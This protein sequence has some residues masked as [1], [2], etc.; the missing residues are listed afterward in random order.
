MTAP[1]LMSDTRDCASEAAAYVLGAL[2]PEEAQAFR[3]HME[4]CV[5]CRDEV[6]A[7]QQ[8]A[9][10]LPMSAPQYQVPKGLRRR[11]LG[12]VRAEPRKPPE[13]SRRLR[14]F[15]RGSRPGLVA[16][17]LA[18][19]AIAIFGGVE[20]VSGGTGIRMIALSPPG[21]GELQLSGGHAELLVRHLSQPPPG[22]IYEVWLQRGDRPPAP[23]STLFSVTSNGTGDI[24]LTGDLRGVSKVLVT[25]EPAGGS[26]IPTHAAVLVARIG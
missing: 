10:A 20:L 24:G 9:D 25:P 4:G 8:V 22:H 2:E 11:V 16:G 13:R 26:L 18:A 6:A 7:F 21:A 15:L 1:D 23:T 17:V 5:V 12:A 14:P 19:A 3:R